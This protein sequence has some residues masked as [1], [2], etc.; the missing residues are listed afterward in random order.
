[1]DIIRYTHLHNLADEAAKEEEPSIDF[2]LPD[3]CDTTGLKLMEIKDVQNKGKG[4]HAKQDLS[5]G[6]LLL[7]SKPQAIIMGWEED[8]FYD[9][10][11]E[12]EEIIDESMDDDNNEDLVKSNRRNGVL[13]IRIAKAIKQNPSLWFDEVSKLFPRDANSLPVWVCE[14]DETGMEFERSIN[15]LETKDE[16]KG[17]RSTVIEEIRQRLP[18][19]VKYNCLSVETSPELFSYPDQS[20]GGHI[21]LSATALYNEPSYFNHSHKPN[22]SRWSIGDIIFFVAN[23]NV[24]AGTELCISYIES[25]LLC[26]TRKEDPPCLRWTLR[27]WMILPQLIKIQ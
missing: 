21:N 10:E 2:P 12:E 23:Q 5:A 17:E 13:T 20:K 16:F 8:E 25:E 22:V 15:E 3:E 27:I 19:I 1:M 6:A 4:F 14:H 11:E 18:F 7:V 9:D 24:K 26:R